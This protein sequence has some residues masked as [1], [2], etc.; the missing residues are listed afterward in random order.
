MDSS[1]LKQKLFSILSYYATVKKLRDIENE[2]PNT[3]MEICMIPG[4]LYIHM[5]DVERARRRIGFE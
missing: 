1:S 2:Y 5:K 3:M 4:L